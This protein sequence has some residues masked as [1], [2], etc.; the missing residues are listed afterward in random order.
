MKSRK[1]VVTFLL[2]L[3]IIS[4]VILSPG[5]RKSSD[6]GPTE[7]NTSKTVE[8]P[9]VSKES[10]SDSFELCV[11]CGHVKGDNLCC[12][13]GQ[14][15]CPD[16]G[17][18]KGSPGCCNIPKGATSAAVCI[19]CGQMKDSEL[20]CKPNQDKCTDCGFIKDSPGCKM[21]QI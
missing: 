13:P 17:L 10:G 15:K 20:C 1:C 11:K 12:K 14:T 18:A 6:E 3:T 5:C 21:F 4:M 2:S 7:P 8:K 9:T 16:C 19:K